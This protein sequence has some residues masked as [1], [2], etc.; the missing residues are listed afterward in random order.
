MIP[1]NKNAIKD[2]DIKAI[3]DNL[4]NIHSVEDLLN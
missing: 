3:S 2:A 1:K 4:N